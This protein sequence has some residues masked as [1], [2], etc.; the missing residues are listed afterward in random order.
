MACVAITH[1]AAGEGESVS[2]FGEVST[3]KIRRASYS[4]FESSAEPD[5]GLPPHAHDGQDEAIYVLAGEYQLSGGDDR[6]TLTV[7]S[8][9][10]VSR[11]TVHCLPVSGT[12]PARCLVIL[13]PPGAMERFLDEVCTASAATGDAGSTPDIFAVARSLGIALLTSP[14]EDAMPQHRTPPTNRFAMT[15]QLVPADHFLVVH[16]DQAGDVLDRA[17]P[18]PAAVW[19]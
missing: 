9:A 2:V 3:F 19:G 11:G 10:L 1:L 8:V 18:A 16:Q 13:D 12:G 4:V 7:G 5:R 15:S 17:A 6:L 14:Y